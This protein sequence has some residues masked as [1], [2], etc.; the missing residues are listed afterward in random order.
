[1]I[2]TA[3]PCVTSARLASGSR[4]IITRRGLNPAAWHARA[5]RLSPLGATH[6]SS[7]SAASG[8]ESC[9]VSG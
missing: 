7:A 8:I 5:I 2:V 3:M 4:E 1:M 6:G 9:A